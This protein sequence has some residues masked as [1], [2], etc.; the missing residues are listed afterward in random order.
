M[1]ST[2]LEEFSAIKKMDYKKQKSALEQFHARH[3]YLYF[4]YNQALKTKLG[5]VVAN[6]DNKS[7]QDLLNDY[8][9]LL[10]K[11]LSYS[12]TTANK[13][14]AYDHMYGYVKRDVTADEREHYEKLKKQFLA[15]ATHE[16]DLCAYVKYLAYKYNK[17]YLKNQSILKDKL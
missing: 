1:T 7:L 16:V 4:T 13:I 8:Q 2:I 14:N 6:H 11:L 15:N 9:Y 17:A 10:E 5:Q 3:K 12:P